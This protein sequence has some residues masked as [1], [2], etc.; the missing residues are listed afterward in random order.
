MYLNYYKMMVGRQLVSVTSPPRRIGRRRGGGGSKR[1]A[2]KRAVGD[3]PTARLSSTSVN[4]TTNQLPRTPPLAGC[5][6]IRH[7][8]QIMRC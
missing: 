1:A 3:G 2:R 5:D 8:T 7:A 6:L 4:P